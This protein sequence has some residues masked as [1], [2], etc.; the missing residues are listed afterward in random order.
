MYL[1]MNEEECPIC[2]FLMDEED[3]IIHM[4][5][6]NHK[7]HI[8]CVVE[9]Y[10]HNKDQKKCFICNQVNKF[11]V[12]LVNISPIEYLLDSD[13]NSSDEVIPEVI[14]ETIEHD[15]TE[16]TRETSTSTFRSN[17]SQI[18]SPDYKKACVFLIFFGGFG[19]LAI[20][21]VVLIFYS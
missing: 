20:A 16:I 14:E 9:W 11:C 6:C 18:E 2:F 21:A 4:E 12:D 10:T 3:G 19:S 13:Q 7:I 8:K 5:C 17:N 15:T 1:K